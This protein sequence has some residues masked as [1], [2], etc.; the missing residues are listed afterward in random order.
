MYI[1]ENISLVSFYSEKCFTKVVKNVKRRFMLRNTIFYI[2]SFM[3][4]RKILYNRTRHIWEYGACAMHVGYLKLQIHFHKMWYLL[5][6]NCN[7]VCTNAHQCYFIRTVPA[8]CVLE[9]SIKLLLTV[10]CASRIFMCFVPLI[11]SFEY[12]KAV[13]CNFCCN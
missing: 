5:I 9:R 11:V 3:R 12:W 1:Y 10:S 2:M 6:Y 8:L 4:R 7:N 13:I